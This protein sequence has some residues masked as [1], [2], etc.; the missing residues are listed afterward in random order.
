MSGNYHLSEEEQ[1]KHDI[2]FEVGAD[3]YIGEM[4]RHPEFKDFELNDTRDIF[5]DEKDIYG[6]EF[7]VEFSWY[8]PVYAPYLSEGEVQVG[9]IV[10]YQ[11]TDEPVNI[12]VVSEIN[13]I[14]D[15]N[16]GEWN[17][18]HG[19]NWTEIQYKNLFNEHETWKTII[20]RDGGLYPTAFLQ[21]G[22]RHD[23]ECFIGGKTVEE[24]IKAFYREEVDK[25]VEFREWQQVQRLDGRSGHEVYSETHDERREQILEA[26]SDRPCECLEG[27]EPKFIDDKAKREFEQLYQKT[28]DG[29]LVPV[30]DEDMYKAL[31]NVRQKRNA[32]NRVVIGN[33]D[34]PTLGGSME[35]LPEK[36]NNPRV[37][38]TYYGNPCYKK[39]EG[40]ENYDP[41]TGAHDI[42]A[43]A[44]CECLEDKEPN[45]VSGE[46]KEEFEKSCQTKVGD[47]ADKKERVKPKRLPPSEHIAQAT[48]RAQEFNKGLSDSSRHVMKQTSRLR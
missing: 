32:E 19:V 4:K 26:M 20:N 41:L 6:G 46:A 5:I 37:G 34:D 13:V 11:T 8:N 47:V 27:K 22:R 40:A 45:F 3:D 7:R 38:E 15:Y 14:D 12:Y 1:E 31:E 48:Q 42:L 30:S 28:Q 10:A 17:R 29:K 24:N 39:I 36:N 33:I 21:V 35:L 44:H 43:G 2:L 9:D 18:E 25:C 16:K 23:P